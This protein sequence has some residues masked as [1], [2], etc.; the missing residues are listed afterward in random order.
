M[1]SNRFSESHYNFCQ[2]SDKMTIFQFCTITHE[3]FENFH[4]GWPMNFFKNFRNFFLKKIFENFRK[5]SW[6]LT[7]EFFQNFRKFLGSKNFLSTW[8]W[9]KNHQT[10]VL[11]W[12]T[13][14][15]I[16]HYSVIFYPV[17]EYSKIS[18]FGAL[19][20]ESWSF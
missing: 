11:K 4:D 17:A 15:T 2:S 7:H 20:D 5:F 12:F 13:E 8:Q 19:E 1:T 16:A 6:W 3:F 18:R 14:S 9:D 10:E